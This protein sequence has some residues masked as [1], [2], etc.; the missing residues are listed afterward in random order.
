MDFRLE[1]AKTY[2][3]DEVE[4]PSLHFKEHSDQL[5]E[6]SQW[7]SE[8]GVDTSNTRL[9]TYIKFLDSYINNDDLKPSENE[10]DKKIYDE[11]Q[12]VLR[13]VHE[14]MWIYNGFKNNIPKGSEKLFKI[15]VGGKIFARDD[16][17]TSARNY[18]LELRIASYFLRAKYEVD[19]EHPTDIIAYSSKDKY[20]IECKRLSSPKKVNTRI[21]E[22]AKQLEN[23]IKKKRF[24]S[25]DLGIAVFDVTK[26][27]FPHQGLTW[28]MTY[29]HCRDVIQNKLKELEGIYDFAGPFVKNKNVIL[30]WIQIH[31]PSLH[32]LKGHPTTRF[33]S[34]FLPLIPQAGFR[35]AA[36]ERL[37]QVIEVEPHEI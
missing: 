23:K 13:E 5:K 17:D 34:L 8:M 31:I 24:R 2:K 25:K 33:S 11:M 35:A 14:L 30:V 21:K 26:L 27:A 16:K 1:D 22:A 7:L 4:I 6:L 15:I 12:Y 37:K 20:F 36:F 19:L 18:Q 3:V 32:I 29:E 28:G 10:K 9:S